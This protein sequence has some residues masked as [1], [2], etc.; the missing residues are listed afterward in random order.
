VIERPVEQQD[1]REENRE[2]QAVEDHR[3]PVPGARTETSIAVVATGLSL[4]SLL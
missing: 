2:E 1:D 4:R 3:A